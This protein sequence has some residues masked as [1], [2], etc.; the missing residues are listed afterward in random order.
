[1]Q[2]LEISSVVAKILPFGGFQHHGMETE[3]GIVEE[4]AKW[5]E[6]DLPPADVLVTVN[7]AAQRVLGVV[8][9]EELEVVKAY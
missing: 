4:H 9:M 2:N 5:F 3:A 1:M 7:A 8:E 6:A